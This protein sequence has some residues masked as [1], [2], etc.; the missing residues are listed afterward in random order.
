MSVD[1]YLTRAADRGEV[2]SGV[3]KSMLGLLR[4]PIASLTQ[5]ELDG[6]LGAQPGAVRQAD[7]SWRVFLQGLPAA[8][9]R[10]G[11]L[12]NV[13]AV[14][15][16]ANYSNPAFVST[17]AGLVGAV[18]LWAGSLRTTVCDGDL[19][20][21]RPGDF[22][23]VSPAVEAWFRLQMTMCDRMIG[24]LRDEPLAPLEFPF[25]G[26][27]AVTDYFVWRYFPTSPIPDLA[28]FLEGLA[29]DGRIHTRVMAF[30]G[31]KPGR[32]T[33]PPGSGCLVGAAPPDET[34]LATCM[35]SGDGTELTL[36]C[37][38][39]PTPFATLADGVQAVVEAI[40]AQDTS[41]RLT[42]NGA[43]ATPQLR[44]AVRGASQGLGLDFLGWWL[45]YHRPPE[46]T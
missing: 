29:L 33:I 34:A 42:L 24:R 2:E 31:L 40:L 10:L 28:A 43:D 19:A 11:R 45:A 6:L 41:A 8:V 35:L 27:D 38:W 21:L 36:R 15:V 37:R 26:G 46:P 32:F 20:F 9:V 44:S 39:G 22:Q 5:D 12:G 18:V 7:G 23:P 16:E 3:R 1:L 13:D 17:L 14:H 25:L 30:H 4:T